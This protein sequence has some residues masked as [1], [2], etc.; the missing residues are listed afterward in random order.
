MYAIVYN[1]EPQEIE[2]L[3]GRKTLQA[4][5]LLGY[6][7]YP[8]DPAWND[9]PFLFVQ[10]EDISKEPLAWKYENGEWLNV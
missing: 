7:N 9:K 1:G 2:T 10:V 6:T 4:G 8:D 3:Q 5:M